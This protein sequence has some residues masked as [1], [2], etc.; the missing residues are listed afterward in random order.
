MN[1]PNAKPPS[2]PK[3]VR[4]GQRTFIIWLALVLVFLA[5]WQFQ[6]GDPSDTSK[7]HFDMVFWM[8]QIMF[9][10]FLVVGTIF[11][12]RAR[13]LSQQLV[14][15]VA[16]V[17]RGEVAQGETAL[18]SLSQSNQLLVRAQALFWLATLAERR[19]DFTRALEL[20]DAGLAALPK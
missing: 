12:M 11:F 17:A 8:P 1:E 9:G 10:A 16:L 6:E 15:A 3:P 13:R 19:A 7:P 5:V 18:A 2:A 4:T 20:C 14:R